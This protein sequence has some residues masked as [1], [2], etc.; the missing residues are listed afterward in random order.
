VVGSRIGGGDRLVDVKVL[1]SRWSGGQQEHR[2]QRPHTQSRRFSSRR[3]LGERVLDERD[4]RRF[5]IA[6]V[7]PYGGTFII[8]APVWL[9]HR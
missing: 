9:R 1:S 2:E 4:P 8:A 5:Y 6:Q 3:Q 7:L